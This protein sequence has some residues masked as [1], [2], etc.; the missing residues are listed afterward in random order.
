MP[1]NL[2]GRVALVTGAS[3]GIGAGIATAMAGAGASVV[4]NYARDKDGAKDV[5]A[6][7][8]AAGGRVDTMGHCR[9][10][11]PAKGCLGYGSRRRHIGRARR[12]SGHSRAVPSSLSESAPATP[13]SEIAL[14][15]GYQTPSALSPCFRRLL[16][17]TPAGISTPSLVEAARHRNHFA[18]DPTCFVGCQ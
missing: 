7:I 2:E 10:S 12:A 6:A 5:V 13:I 8:E 3:N 4:V 9:F 1:S 15:V 18:C 11:P 14:T 17:V 16:G